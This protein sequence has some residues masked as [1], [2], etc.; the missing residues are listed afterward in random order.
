MLW[1]GD[2][3]QHHPLWDEEWNKHLFTAGA[4]SAVQLLLSL[5]EDYD[6]IMLL[7]KGLPT[8]QSTA[9]KNWTLV[10]NVFTMANMEGLVVVCDTDPVQRGPGTDHVPILT[11]LDISVPHRDEERWSDFRGTD[12]DEFRKVLGAQ[13][14]AIPEPCMLQTESQFQNAVRDLTKALQVTIET[15]MPLSCPL[16]HL[17]RWWNKDLACRKKEMKWLASQAYKFHTIEDHPAHSTFKNA[18]TE[19]GVAVKWAKEQH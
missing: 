8:M 19:Y 1:C 12:W 17:R 16:P 5:I 14:S 18:C 6:I 11:M 13:L 2:F 3:T 15:T 7:P 9:T 10:N 4:A